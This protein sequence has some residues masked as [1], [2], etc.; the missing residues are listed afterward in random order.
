[1]AEDLLPR[2]YAL[3]GPGR[4]PVLAALAADTEEVPLAPDEELP[5]RDGHRRLARLADAAAGDHLERG[6]GFDDGR[7]ALLGEEIDF[8]VGVD[9]RG[10][11]RPAD[12]LLPD[13]LA[14]GRLQAGGDALVGDGEQV[15]LDVHRRG[16]HRHGLALRPGGVGARDV[17]AAAQADGAE[18]RA[19]EA[20]APEDQAVAVD[21]RGD[22]ALA[23]AER[24]PQPPAV[25]R[26]EALDDVAGAADDLVLAADAHDDGGGVADARRAAAGPPA[27]PAGVLV[28][29]QEERPLPRG[30]PADLLVVA[31][32]AVVGHHQQVAI[33]DRRGAQAVD[34]E[35]L[36]VAVGPGHLAVVVQRH[37]AAVAEGRVDACAVGDG[38]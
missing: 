2:L 36:D 13:H 10:R 31:A 16:D 12:A 19:A 11:V 14:G 6:P 33:E 1:M 15:R 18:G 3:G 32:A 20:G 21:R 22:D 28:H 9:R 37:Q 38:G 5:A 25:G 24:R 26:V 34:A 17:A 29:G 4:R 35:E 27:L 30:L 7:L 23:G 8:A